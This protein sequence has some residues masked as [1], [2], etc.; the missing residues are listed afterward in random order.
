VPAEN[1]HMG[2]M[3]Y[4]YLQSYTTDDGAQVLIPNRSSL[5]N[6]MVQ[7]FGGNYSQ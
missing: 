2:V 7:V 3:D 1:I 4:K 5:G 6:L